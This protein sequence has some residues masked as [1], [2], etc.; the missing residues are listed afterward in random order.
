MLNK[1]CHT[2]ASAYL[3]ICCILKI[4]CNTVEMSC[5]KDRTTTVIVCQTVKVDESQQP[6]MDSVDDFSRKH[7]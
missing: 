5:K 6:N 4:T 7:K 1:F 2:N 3:S